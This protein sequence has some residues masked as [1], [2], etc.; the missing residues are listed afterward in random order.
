MIK[1]PM[2]LVSF[3]LFYDLKNGT[4]EIFLSRLLLVKKLKLYFVA[5]N[6]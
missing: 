5:K 6:G 3:D 1:K 4:I 2:T